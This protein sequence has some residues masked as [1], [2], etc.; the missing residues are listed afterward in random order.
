M[1]RL[2]VNPSFTFGC[3]APGIGATGEPFFFEGSLSLATP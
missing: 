1:G 3:V 2:F